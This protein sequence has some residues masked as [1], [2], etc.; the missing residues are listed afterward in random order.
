MPSQPHSG[1]SRGGGGHPNRASRSPSSGGPRGGSTCE[2]RGE[3]GRPGWS[4]G[5][6]TQ[7]A[8]PEHPYLDVKGR[9]P[10]NQLPPLEGGAEP[11][12]EKGLCSETLL[13]EKSVPSPPVV[14]GHLGPRRLLPV[15]SALQAPGSAG[16]EGPPAATELGTPRPIPRALPVPQGNTAQVWLLGRV[17][18]AQRGSP[19]PSAP[20]SSG[21]AS[22]AFFFFFFKLH[23]PSLG[24]TVFSPP[25]RM[26]PPR[27]NS[28][29]G[30]AAG[31]RREPPG[32]AAGPEPHGEFTCGQ[33]PKPTKGP[34]P[35][36]AQ[37]DCFPD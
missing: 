15:A 36:F 26:M 4:V 18:K 9:G 1:C 28:R 2:G 23:H 32:G 5:G 34:F 6:H 27:G 11:R 31:P 13:K 35:P 8:G 22:A 37:E 25:W 16:D 7:E 10:C 17:T 12:P 30:R 29:L 14:S 24:F 33:V 21:L 3:G 20:E 19:C